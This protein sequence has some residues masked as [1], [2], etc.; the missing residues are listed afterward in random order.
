MAAEIF[1]AEDGEIYIVPY[2][3]ESA[4]ESGATGS[5]ILDRYKYSDYVTE[6]AVS[7]GGRETETIYTFGKTSLN[8][9]NQIQRE[10]PQE[11]YET[12]LTAIVR[13]YKFNEMVNG[14][15]STASGVTTVVGAA[16]RPDLTIYYR[17]S[18]IDEPG[19]ENN[20][21]TQLQIKFSQATGTSTE[22]SADSEGMLE[23]T[24]GFQILATNYEKKYAEDTASG[25]IWDWR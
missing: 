7:G 22:M 18:D 17:F 10:L 2:G 8:Q 11:M 23:E 25:S 1:Y 3:S 13:D 15:G 20:H 9:Q 16:T 4:F 19:D 24:T 5:A 6:I 12:S 14:T 21:G